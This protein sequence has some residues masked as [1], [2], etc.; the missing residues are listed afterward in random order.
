MEMDENVLNYIRQDKLEDCKKYYK[1]LS[2]KKIDSENMQGKSVVEHAF[3]KM[4]Q[5]YL[6]PLDIEMH[7][8]PIE[9]FI[10]HT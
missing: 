9:E 2:D 7:F 8:L 10:N 1:S 6:D 4:L 3:Y 5:G